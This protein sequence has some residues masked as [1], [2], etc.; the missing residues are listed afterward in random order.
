MSEAPIRVLFVCLG[1]ICRSPT[2]E[3]VFRHVVA[4]AGLTGRFDIDSAGTGSWHVG[5]PPDAR[6]TAAAERRGIRLS[7][8]ARQLRRD[9]L[10]GYHYILAMDADNLEGIERLR[11]A[12]ARAD[13]RLF[14]EFDPEARGRLDVPDPYYGGPDG[15]DEVL[16]MVERAALG[17]L[18]HIRR[19]HAF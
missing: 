11:D 10:R 13:I 8:R 1:N 6:A 14:R 16:D 19:E 4:E 18:T 9:D 15:F 3:G 7:G 2:A 12:A 5:D 17:L